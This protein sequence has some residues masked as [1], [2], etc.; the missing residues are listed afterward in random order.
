MLQPTFSGDKIQKQGNSNWSMLDDPAINKAIDEAAPIP[1]GAERSRAFA[2][3]NKKIVEQAV[4]VPYSWDDSFQL[5]S[6]DVQG[7]MNGY[8]TS[9]DLSFSFVK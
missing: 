9:W 5:A 6:K 7:V 1:T 2:A 3:I 4:A 8:S